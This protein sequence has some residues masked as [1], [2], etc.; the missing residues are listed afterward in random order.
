MITKL[1]HDKMIYSRRM[2][3]LTELISEMLR[4]G[5]RN[6]LDVGCG[7]GRIDSYLMQ[8]NKKLHIRGIDILVRPKTYIEVTEYDGYHIPMADNEVDV[9]IIIDVLHHVDEPELLM[10]ELVRVSSS[11][12]IIKDHIRSNLLSYIK[13]RLMDYVGNAHYHV[14]L[15]YN[16]MT[17]KQWKQMFQDNGLCIQEYNM[18]LHLYKGIFHYL[19]DR[20]LH[21]I[22][23][24]EVKNYE[25]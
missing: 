7:D 4:G 10:K 23:K 25:T 3:R 1:F 19:F 24:L 17:K 15:P 14:R 6:V 18:D 12:I 11:T 16:Y 13:L 22:T 2:E 20:N 21:F 5:V 8:K 9:V